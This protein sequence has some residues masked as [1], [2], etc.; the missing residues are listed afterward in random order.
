MPT[1]RDKI[2]PAA[3]LPDAAVE[4]FRS[5]QLLARPGMMQLNGNYQG[6]I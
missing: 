1:I 4:V 3:L 2:T 5:I 6:Q